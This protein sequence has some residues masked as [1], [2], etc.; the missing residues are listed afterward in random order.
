MARESA[1]EMI[2]D[3]QVQYLDHEELQA[4]QRM[5]VGEMNIEG[6]EHNIDDEENMVVNSGYI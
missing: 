2:G 6:G 4:Q 5:Q 3:A 1:Q